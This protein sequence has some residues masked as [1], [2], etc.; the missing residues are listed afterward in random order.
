MARVMKTEP[1]SN[2]AVRSVELRTVHS[3]NN[4][5]FLR[6]PINKTVLLVENEMVRFPTEGT[7]KGQ[8][9]IIT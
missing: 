3:L 1:D 7:N 8:D 2:G 9:D 5:K 6:R 4:E